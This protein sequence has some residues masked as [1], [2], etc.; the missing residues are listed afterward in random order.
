MRDFASIPR[1]DWLDLAQRFYERL[2]HEIAQLSP[3]VWS[4]RTP[5]LG[6]TAHDVLAHMASS[7]PVNFQEVVG[8]ALEGDPSA[9]AE[10]D[11]FQRNARAVLERRSMAP[12]ALLEELEREVQELLQTFRRISD[13]DWLKPA[14]FFI[15]PVRVRSLFLILFGDDLFHERDLLIA[16]RSWQGLD[17]QFLDPLVDWFLREHRPANFRPDRAGD[18]KAAVLYRLTGVGGGEWTLMIERGTCR[19][20]PGRAGHADVFLD[21]N[22]EDLIAAALARSSPWI[23]WMG[24][25]FAGAMPSRNREDFLATVTGVGSFGSAILARRIRIT[26]NS[27]VMRKLNGCFWHFWE[28]TR[29]TDENIQKSA[30]A[31][32]LPRAFST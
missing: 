23:G 10:Y 26:G 6:W 14:W 25:T 3:N 16:A 15:G 22:T 12:S 24:R 4:R 30:P 29:Q 2:F 18:L 8:R 28:R 21:A 27:R 20:L 9:P 11:T 13:D 31:A 17:P 7:V 19:T 1:S 32:R 5:Y